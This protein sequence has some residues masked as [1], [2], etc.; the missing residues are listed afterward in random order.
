MKIKYALKKNQLEAFKPV[1]MAIYISF[2]LEN[3]TGLYFR[4]KITTMKTILL[5]WRFMKMPRFSIKKK[6][7]L[8]ENKGK[9]G[10]YRWINLINVKHISEVP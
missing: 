2:I 9:A 6:Q 8:S 3:V 5:Q 7:I 4:I 10:V 1:K